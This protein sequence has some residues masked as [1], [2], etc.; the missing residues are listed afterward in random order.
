MIRL[1][2][3]VQALLSKNKNKAQRCWVN[4]AE[5]TSREIFQKSWRVQKPKNYLRSCP[6]IRRYFPESA[7]CLRPDHRSS[8]GSPTKR[9]GS[10]HQAPGSQFLQLWLHKVWNSKEGGGVEEGWKGRQARWVWE[11]RKSHRGW[12]NTDAVTAATAVPAPP[13]V[14]HL[15]NAYKYEAGTRVMFLELWRQTLCFKWHWVPPLT[16][17]ESTNIHTNE[18]PQKA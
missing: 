16:S 18:R 7:G 13:A 10:E 9:K 5:Q 1:C 6:Y 14:C 11:R 4:G 2:G 12:R 8:T 15:T 17:P 3:T